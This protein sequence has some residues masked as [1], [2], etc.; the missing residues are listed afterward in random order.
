M[1][2]KTIART[3][4]F[5]SQLMELHGE[6]SFKVKSMANAAFKVDKLPFPIAN[7]SLSEIEQIEGLGKST[8]SK[9]WEFIHQNSITEL[10]KLL[11]VT[12]EGVAE[13]LQ[14]KGIGPKKIGV[15]WKDLGIENTGEL[16]YACNENRLIEAKGFG[17]KTQEEIIK[18][19][20]FKMASSGR[21]LYAKVEQFAENLIEFLR[22]NIETGLINHTGDYRRKCEIIDGLDI[23]CSIPINDET[24]K[25]IESAGLTVTKNT[26]ERLETINAEGLNVYFYFCAEN[27]FGW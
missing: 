5:L 13:M 8:A 11:E 15:I 10:N 23:L 3:L 24:I 9:V 2:N 6:N 20:D 18:I 25:L 26:D 19:L 7:K 14:I 21:H 27:D 17:L 12:P 4:R 22:G 16:Y 1:E